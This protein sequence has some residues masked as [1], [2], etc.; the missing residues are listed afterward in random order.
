MTRK[1]TQTDKDVI[2]NLLQGVEMYLLQFIVMACSRVRGD[3]DQQ[4]RLELVHRME[5][6]R[7][8]LLDAIEDAWE[9]KP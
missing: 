4:E 2:D 1:L 6:T 9:A 8:Y 3:A 5:Q 7:D